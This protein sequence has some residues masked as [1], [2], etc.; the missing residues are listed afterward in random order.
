MDQD[1]I[2]KLRALYPR[3]QEPDP[4]L[5]KTAGAR[6]NRRWIPLHGPYKGRI[7][8]EH[9]ATENFEWIGLVFPGEEQFHAFR[10]GDL[11]PAD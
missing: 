9:C 1:K 3:G 10:F 2:D 7:G 8:A 4:A 5:M 11:K 6:P